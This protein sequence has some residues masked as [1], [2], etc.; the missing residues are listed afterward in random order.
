MPILKFQ[1][2]FCGLTQRKRV[3][4]KTTKIVCS[5]GEY[6]FLEGTISDISVGFNASV[7]NS[8]SVQDTG[9]ESFDLSFDR[10]IGEEA[11]QQWEVIYRRNNDKLKLMN[12][13]KIKGES[14]MRTPEGS[15]KAMPNIAKSTKNARLENMKRLDLL[16]T[17][18]KE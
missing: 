14:I 10:V 7:K 17:S 2:T 15:Y 4:P 6:S 1:C 13:A 5:C 9:I 3:S 12:E 18:D 8:L 16:L 11:K